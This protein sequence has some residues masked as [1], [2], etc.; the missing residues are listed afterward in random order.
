MLSLRTKILLIMAHQWLR[1]FVLNWQ[2][3]EIICTSF[4]KG[5]L[6]DFK[7]L[8]AS[9]VHLHPACFWLANSGYQGGSSPCY[10]DSFKLN[11]RGV[12]EAYVPPL[13]LHR[14]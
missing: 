10:V 7:L 8:Q 4:G 13:E 5:R 11:T 12:V 1:I 2:T 9:N 3:R 14:R 6:H